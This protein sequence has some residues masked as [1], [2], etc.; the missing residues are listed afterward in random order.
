[1][2]LK[3]SSNPH[4][5]PGSLVEL[6]CISPCLNHVIVGRMRTFVLNQDAFLLREQLRCDKSR[7]SQFLPKFPPSEKHLRGALRL[8][9]LPRN[10]SAAFRESLDAVLDVGPDVVV[11]REDINGRKV[12]QCQLS[13]CER[14]SWR[15][16]SRAVLSARGDAIKFTGY[17]L[18]L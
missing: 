7:G 16:G 5:Q 13:Q 14:V 3:T 10:Q 8:R 6:L 18:V 12:A 1:M 4:F 17:F 9:A 2:L 11:G 15:T